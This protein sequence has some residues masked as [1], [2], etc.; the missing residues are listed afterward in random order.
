[1]RYEMLTWSPL[2]IRSVNAALP[3][4]AAAAVLAPLAI[5]FVVPSTMNVCVNHA[6]PPLEPTMVSQP[7]AIVLTVPFDVSDASASAMDPPSA[8]A[9]GID[10]MIEA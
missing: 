8:S 9:W 7:G 1:M 10:L 4:L 5:T 3:P 2:A 6:P